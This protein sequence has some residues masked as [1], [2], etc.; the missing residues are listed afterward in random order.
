MRYVQ[1][2]ARGAEVGDPELA[3]WSFQWTAPS[4]AAGP[5]VFHAAANSA[6]GD[7]SPLGDLVYTAELRLEP[8]APVR[9]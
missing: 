1:Q 6:N 4:D 9:R 3:T 8:A 5:V 7:N 2:V